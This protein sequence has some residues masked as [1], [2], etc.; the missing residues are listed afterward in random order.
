M[1]SCPSES[2]VRKEREQEVYTKS[3][4]FLRRVVANL[5]VLEG[6]SGRVDAAFKV[7]RKKILARVLRE[8]ADEL[9]GAEKHRR[10][11]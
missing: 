6:I 2:E 7:N 4:D 8:Q 5:L 9:E 1:S 11:R 3:R 10:K